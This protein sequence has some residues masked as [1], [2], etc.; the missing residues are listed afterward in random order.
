MSTSESKARRYSPSFE[1]NIGPIT[2][3]LRRLPLYGERILEVGSGSGQHVCA[4]SQSVTREDGAPYLW[5]PTE[6]RGE[7]ESILAWREAL[8]VSDRVAAPRE[9]D[10]LE[11]RWIEAVAGGAPYAMVASVNVAHIVAWSGVVNLIQ[12]A[13]ELMGEGGV[14]YFYGPFRSQDRELEPSNASFDEWL[15]A[16]YPEGGGLRDE[17]EVTQAAERVGFRRGGD[18]AMPANNRSLWFVKGAFDRDATTR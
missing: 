6:R 8:G 12:G 11:E 7:L 13:S 1:R 14:L 10:L 4:W 18:E 3:V 16:H 5:Q 15:K 9:I 2:Q 17:G